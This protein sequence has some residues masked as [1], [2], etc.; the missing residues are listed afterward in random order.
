MRLVVADVVVT[1]QAAGFWS[2]NDE[3]Q[4][5]ASLHRSKTQANPQTAKP[6]QKLRPAAA[7][8]GF[9]FVLRRNFRLPTVVF[10]S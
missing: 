2:F 8:N 7:P 6:D 1:A 10:G 9:T 3:T 5:I 4:N